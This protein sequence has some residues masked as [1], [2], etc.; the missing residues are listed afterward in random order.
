[1]AENSANKIKS[2]IQLGRTLEV[3]NL[4][5]DLAW[6]IRRNDLNNSY[7][8]STLSEEIAR[9]LNYEMG[10]SG[11]LKSQG[12]CLW[13]FSDYP[14]SMQKNT[15][16]LKIAEQNNDLKEQADI[17]N[18]IGAVYMFLKDNE[19]RLKCNLRCLEIRKEIGDFE[20]VSGSLNNTGET[21]L[22]MDELEM[23][24]KFFNDCLNYEHSVIDSKGWARHNLGLLFKRKGDSKKAILNLQESIE[25][26]EEHGYHILTCNSYYQLALL[27]FDEENFSE[28]LGFLNKAFD[29]A[30]TMNTK[31]E[32]Q[33]IHLIYSQIYEKQTDLKSALEHYKKYSDYHNQ[34][35][36]E[37]NSANIRN[38]KNQYEVENLKKEAEIERLKNTELKKAFNEIDHQK[39]IVE[40]KN[41]SI[42]ASINYAKRIQK[43][44]LENEHELEDTELDYFKIFLPKDVVSGDFY[45]SKLV[46][47]YF[48]LAVVD[49][50]GHGVPGA[51][52]SMLGV[53]FLNEITSSEMLPT[54][55]SILDSL[56]EKVITVLKQSGNQYSNADGMDMSIIRLDLESLEMQFSGAM[57][58]LYIVRNEY[59]EIE[60][61]KGDRM[62]I[63]YS[64]RMEPFGLE[65][66][67]LDKGDQ[68][69]MFSDGFS[70]QFGGEK[71]RKFGHKQFR[72][73]LVNSSKL[74][75]SE[76]NDH[77]LTQFNNWKG[78]GSQIDDV[79]LIGIE[80]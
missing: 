78:T 24:E 5:N 59:D 71:N 10:I 64:N 33:N 46:G 69:F 43:A 79:T 31:E 47:S 27:L 35:Y 80:V 62:P 45:W 4:L 44:I 68:F 41:E 74:N 29:L 34:I 40:Q 30:T 75:H 58:P 55:N 28:A 66:I 63:G 56:R 51:F 21:Y 7:K 42:N 8:A 13:R 39:K 20:G 76:R 6:E 11:A 9:E 19:N 53:A 38:L 72:Q 77:I 73:L 25:I 15:E 50:T 67:D 1:M 54:T 18:S 60:E 12:Y 37:Q 14:S 16:A 26:T 2:I 57:N 49:C 70:D 22:E 52:M 65:F 32:L 17:L 23:A 48:Y 61:I 3:V 36:N